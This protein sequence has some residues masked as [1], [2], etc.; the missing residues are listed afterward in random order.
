MGVNGQKNSMLTFFM[1]Y[2]FST[3]V[4]FKIHAGFMSFDKTQQKILNMQTATQ[5]RR[6]PSWTG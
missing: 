4:F 5:N 2:A 3:A 1:I 6:H